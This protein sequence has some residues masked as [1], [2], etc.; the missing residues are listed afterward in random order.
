[1]P[2]RRLA[3][4]VHNPTHRGVAASS[5]NWSSDSSM[6]MGSRPLPNVCATS[7]RRARPGARAADRGDHRAMTGR[8][9]RRPLRG[10]SYG[11]TDR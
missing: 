1:M 10:G 11:R 6:S 2:A 9:C 4:A 5:S 8:C 7:K 3:G